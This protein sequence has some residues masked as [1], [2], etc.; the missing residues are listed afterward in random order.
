MNRSVVVYV[1]LAL[2][3]CLTGSVRAGSAGIVPRPVGRQYPGRRADT[4]KIQ[5]KLDEIIIPRIDFEEATIPQ[6]IAFLQKRSKQLDP[7]GEGVNI[8][9]YLEDKGG[10]PVQV[11][12]DQAD[13]EDWD[14]RFDDQPEPVPATEPKRAPETSHVRQ[15]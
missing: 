10:S 6:V 12:F 2:V 15:R 14:T 9:L 7:D 11:P 1:L 8:I 5:R 4:R 3:L 13:S